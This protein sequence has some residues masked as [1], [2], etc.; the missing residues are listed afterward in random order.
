MLGS[1]E[2]RLDRRIVAF[3]GLR[4]IAVL[5]V[6]L[7]HAGYN[8]VIEGRIGVYVFFT[9]S[10]FLITTI[11]ISELAEG[12]RIGLSRFYERR[13][14]RLLPAV[15]VLVLTVLALG[16]LVDRADAFRPPWVGVGSVLLYVANWLTIRS[17]AT[18]LGAF[19]HL[20]SLSVE[21]Q[22][23]L[24]WPLL[25]LVVAG[26]RCRIERLLPVCFAGIVGAFVARTLI[27]RAPTVDLEHLFVGTDTNADHLLTGCALAVVVAAAS[28]E[29][30]TRMAR[31]L[32]FAAIPAVGYFVFEVLIHPHIDIGRGSLEW[33]FP[34]SQTVL[35]LCSAI[36]VGHLL[37]DGDS[38]IVRA[39]SIRPLVR[40]GEI[41]YGWYLWHVPVLR[42][43]RLYLGTDRRVIVLIVALVVTYCVS[44]LSYRYV[45]MPIRRRVRPAVSAVNDPRI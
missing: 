18:E 24:V 41:S 40:L 27:L 14:R 42:F 39:T 16:W 45:E 5:A 31:V 3:D 19:S 29:R 22:F 25:I 9:L 38:A 21:E 35:A 32:R 10:G 26:S 4:G 7:L 13:A 15:G 6:T 36:I 2:R 1:A 43:V 8:K 37:L 44:S 33:W 28:A 23:Y 20:W 34:V 12:G 30:V 11:L 17:G